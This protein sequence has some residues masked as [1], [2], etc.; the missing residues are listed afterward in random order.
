M[1]KTFL[2][3]V[4]AIVMLLAHTHAESVDLEYAAT[5]YAADDL[6]GIYFDAARQGRSDILEGLIDAGAPVDARDKKGYTAFILAS[7]NGHPETVALLAARRANPCAADYKGNTAQMGAAFRGDDAM[8]RKLLEFDCDVNVE[9]ST[10]QTAAMMAALF[11]RTEQVKMLSDA[12]ADLSKRDFAGNTAML[13]ARVQG[14][15]EMVRLLSG[16]QN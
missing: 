15:R 16:R 5:G 6:A 10:G 4:A 3:T 11:G 13:L 1:I 9:N 2:G 8:A 12:G 14:N 7:Y